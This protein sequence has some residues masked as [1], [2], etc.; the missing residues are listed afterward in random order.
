MDSEL[1][2]LALPL[3]YR[4]LAAGVLIAALAGVLGTVVVV[5]RS[6]SP[7]QSR[8]PVWPASRSGLCCVDPPGRARLQ[9][10]R[11]AQVAY[12]TVAAHSGLDT[13]SV[14]STQLR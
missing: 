2:V 12:L 11:G 8:T 9:R 14:S 13:P 6:F 10:H 5:R 4:A 3:F 1:S 7:T